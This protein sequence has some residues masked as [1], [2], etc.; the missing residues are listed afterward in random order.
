VARDLIGR[1]TR[2]RHAGHTVKIGR[3]LALD[4]EGDVEP[5]DMHRIGDGAF[6]GDLRGAG[7]EFEIDRIRN[8]V[9]QSEDRAADHDDGGRRALVAALAG[10]AEIGLT[11]LLVALGFQRQREIGLIGRV[12]VFQLGVVQREVMDLRQFGVCG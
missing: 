2:Q 10:D 8:G 9:A 5:G 1:R 3:I 12:A 6:G 7:C 11:A 4:G